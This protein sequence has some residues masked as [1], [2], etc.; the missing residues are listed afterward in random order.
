MPVYVIII[1]Y[2]FFSD[3]EE[4]EDFSEGINAFLDSV[5]QR[6]QTTRQ[7]KDALSAQH[8][9]PENRIVAAMTFEKAYML[10]DFY[11]LH[12]FMNKMII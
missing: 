7:H 10:V 1:M 2:M 3:D 12:Y 9:G 4:E 11:K 5:R 8:V 6:K